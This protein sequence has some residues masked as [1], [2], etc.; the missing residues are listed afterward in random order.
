[1]AESILND[2]MQQLQGGGIGEISKTL[3]LNDDQV[4]SVVTAAMP[5]LMGAFSR[6]AGSQSGA[7][8]LFGALAGK[9]SGS[10]LGDVVGALAGGKNADTGILKHAFGAKQSGVEQ[11]LSAGSGVDMA[12]VGKIMA[13]V[14]PLV[15]GA[16]GKAQRTQGLD[17]S[18]TAAMI[19]QEGR[20][21]QQQAPQAMDMLGK[22][23]DADGDGDVMDDLG[24]LGSSLLGSFLK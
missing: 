5:A 12:S 18:G 16:L 15:M 23:L 19:Q 9:H 6:N 17:A 3:G 22:L 13:M 11:A 14:A 8:A 24:K 7:D 1:M 4:S 2:L 21:A 20:V 10:I